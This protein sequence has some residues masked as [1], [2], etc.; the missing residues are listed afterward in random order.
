MARNGG[1][2]TGILRVVRVGNRLGVRD[3]M[4]NTCGCSARSASS[5][6]VEVG[7]PGMLLIAGPMVSKSGAGGVTVIN[8]AATIPSVRTRRIG[9]SI[10]GVSLSVDGGAGSV[11]PTAAGSA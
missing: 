1:H 7:K 9:A 2:R 3:V 6:K 11:R 5:L 10:V 8:P 4:M